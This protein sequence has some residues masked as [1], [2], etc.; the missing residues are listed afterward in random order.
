MCLRTMQR[1]T[2]RP[3]WIWTQ[4][5]S[6]ENN[7]EEFPEVYYFTV[8]KYFIPLILVDSPQ[9]YEERVISPTL[10]IT[11]IS[12]LNFIY[13]SWLYFGQTPSLM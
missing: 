2:N 6:R 13:K 9:P 11:Q 12:T 5:E 3:I 10:H 7:T 1:K 4:E 8:R